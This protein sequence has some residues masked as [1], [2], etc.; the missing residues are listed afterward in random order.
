[1]KDRRRPNWDAGRFVVGPTFVALALTC[2][3]QTAPTTQA[4]AAAQ[5]QDSSGFTLK[6]YSRLTVVDVTVTDSKENPVHG[7]PESAFTVLEDGK[8]QPIRSF[9]EVGKEPP[10]VVRQFPK[11]PPHIYTNLQ[12]APASNAVNVLLLDSLNTG[13]QDQVFVKQ[14]TVN[15]LKSMQ[16]G[17]K[18]A[19]M[20]LGSSL[21]LLQ[22]FTSDPE[23][24]LAAIKTKKNRA[25]PSPFSD[26]DTGDIET[27]ASDV[28]DAD[29][30]A[31]I[32]EFQNEQTSFQTDIRNRMT[33]EALNQI[34]AYLAGIKGRKNLIWFTAGIP[35]QMFP[36]GGTDDLA[37]MT[38][39]TKDLRK[40]T[41]EL[42]AA[43]I[44][45][46][47]IDAR[48][49]MTNPSA[50]VVHP[51]TG[52]SS[53]RGD[54][55]G[56]AIAAFDMK[57]GQE[58]LGMDA[59]AEATGGEAYFNTNG[60]KE[61]VQKAINNGQNY[62]AL[63]YVPPDPAYDGVFHK[64]SVKVNV[65]GLHLSYR[66]GYFADDVARNEITPGITLATKA[67]EPYGNNMQAS[68]GRG[69]PTSS[70]LLFTVR[71]EPHAD[72]VNAA[73]TKVLGTLD[74]KLQ[75]KPLRRYDFQYSIPGRQITFNQDAD[76]SHKG[77]LEFDIAAYDVYGKL[78]T[79]I[80]QTI[81]LKL[82][83]ERYQAL[84]RGPFQLE[85]GID[86]PLGEIFLRL[87]IRDT[88]SDKT[89]TI[90]IPIDVNRKP[91]VN[92]TVANKPVKP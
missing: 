91:E 47:P 1:M 36:Q 68:M 52:F 17:T 10:P 57:T 90:E 72:T 14:E 54:S 58:H 25:L 24:L 87:G 61:A 51:P 6:V 70:Q 59:I 76:K 82:T 46:Y 23:V 83:D 56:K 45:V 81:D 39:Y 34:A 79:S 66:K 48:G 67:P 26:V 41:D 77:A 88:V 86:L 19:I 21:R 53:G 49:V 43:Q 13:P 63:S 16:P 80:S 92:A 11:L 30:A 28:A 71:V 85:Q 15:Y 50:S 22:G 5:N 74:P 64:I 37:A 9:S 4:P 62:Y 73:G 42:T 38:D 12:P 78:I 18:I 69:V 33:M 65:P 44:A 3:A 60:L 55:M 27:S 7:L 31:M 2:F 20:T 35:L 84:Q 29:A 40:T 32:Q 8:P 75:G 89:G